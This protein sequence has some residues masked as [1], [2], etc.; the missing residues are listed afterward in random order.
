M[1]PESVAASMCCL[2]KEEGNFGCCV[3]RHKEAP[4]GILS[5]SLRLTQVLIFKCRYSNQSLNLGL[6]FLDNLTNYRGPITGSGFSVLKHKPSF[7]PRQVGSIIP[8]IPGHPHPRPFP[9]EALSTVFCLF[10]CLSMACSSLI[11]SSQT[12]DCTWAAAVKAPNPNH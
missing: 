6:H 3:L 12:R 2:L 8:R 11:P 5:C 9:T 4:L 10:F 7:T 1:V